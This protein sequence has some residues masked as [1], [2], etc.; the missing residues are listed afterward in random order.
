MSCGV[1]FAKRTVTRLNTVNML[2][3][4]G[5]IATIGRRI[6]GRQV[7]DQAGRLRA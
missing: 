5:I 2:C 1:R 3:K 7:S 6:V 4:A